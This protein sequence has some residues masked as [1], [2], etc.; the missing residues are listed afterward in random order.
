MNYNYVYL[1]LFICIVLIYVVRVGNNMEQ[2]GQLNLPTFNKFIK[3]TRGYQCQEKIDAMP[4]RLQIN[5]ERKVSVKNILHLWDL[6]KISTVL[7]PK[8]VEIKKW[9]W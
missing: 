3:Y 8:A 7:V 9:P 6:A 2:F 4:N 1:T 5:M